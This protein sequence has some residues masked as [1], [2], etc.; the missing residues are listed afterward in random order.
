[1]LAWILAALLVILTASVFF[2]C[3]HN[4]AA[5]AVLFCGGFSISAIVLSI[6]QSA[7]QFQ[8]GTSTFLLVLGGNVVFA[9]IAIAIHAMSKRSNSRTIK[10]GH[11]NRSFVEKL[12]SIRP[13]IPN[14]LVIIVFQLV[15]FF[16]T[17]HF[18][19]AFFPDE[20]LSGAIRSYNAASTFSTRDMSFPSPFEQIRS[21]AVTGGYLIAFDFGRNLS[22]LR[23][24][25]SPTKALMSLVCFALSAGLTIELGMRTGAIE[26][27]VCAFVAF[28]I[29]RS[30]LL[31]GVGII[32]WKIVAVLVCLVAVGLA[33]FQFAAIGREVS[34]YSALDYLAEYLGAQISNLNVFMDST[35]F[36]VQH[37]LFGYMTFA[38][39]YSYLGGKLSIDAWI[40]TLDLPFVT[41]N[42]YDLGNVYTTFYAFLYDFGYF[43]VIVFTGIMAV[44]SQLIYEQ[45]MRNNWAGTIWC[46]IYDVV[47]A[48]LLLSFFSNKF[49]ETFNI[50]FAVTIVVLFL[51][52]L[53]FIAPGRTL[54]EILRREFKLPRVAEKG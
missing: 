29:C 32:T 30:K 31:G 44:I 46:V 41:M 3:D 37:E 20:P 13:G 17:L 34:G 12:L 39:D 4:P 54:T 47:G 33:A 27:A 42:G 53:V 5:P 52:Y 38:R 23:K 14:Y 25:E 6:S 24:G 8:L 35:T 51:F 26:V 40:Y 49:Y 43:G 21:L 2:L 50:G 1:M 22:E 9:V 18:V 28:F 19:Q 7:W 11:A 10:S 45:A 48:S 36:P 15:V 16:V